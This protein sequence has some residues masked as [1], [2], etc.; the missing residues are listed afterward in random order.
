MSKIR[1]QNVPNS[2]KERPYC[3]SKEEIKLGPMRGLKKTTSHGTIH[4]RHLTDGH[5]DS[6][7]AQWADSVKLCTNI[8]L[9]VWLKPM[10]TMSY[11]CHQLGV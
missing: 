4:N 10:N 3:H 7:S 2:Q 1:V 11:N 8:I 6:E 5:R 9:V